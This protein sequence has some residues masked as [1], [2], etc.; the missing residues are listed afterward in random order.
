[1]FGLFTKP[2]IKITNKP[3]L[4]DN[5]TRMIELLRDNAFTAQS[6][7]VR[8]VLSPLLLDNDEVF[9]K[10]LN[11]VDMWGGAGAV[12]EVYGFETK[13]NEREFHKLIVDLIILMKEMGIKN[14]HAYALLGVFEKELKK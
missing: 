5:L 11:S 2:K 4:V 12:W 10:A 1:M 8:R 14:R 9:L 6:D 7:A 13:E 3:A